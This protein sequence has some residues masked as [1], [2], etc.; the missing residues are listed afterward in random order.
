VVD[1][2][3]TE[4][5]SNRGNVSYSHADEKWLKMLQVYV[6]PL[7]RDVIVFLWDDTKIGYEFFSKWALV[8]F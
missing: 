7:E 3:S 6:A 1:R 2:G 8:N 5:S 4:A